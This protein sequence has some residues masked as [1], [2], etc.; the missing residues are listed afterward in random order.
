MDLPAFE[1]QVAKAC[2]SSDMK[3]LGKMI[4]EDRRAQALRIKWICHIPSVHGYQ[5]NDDSPLDTNDH[6]ISWCNAA[7]KHPKKKP[8]VSL[9][10]P[11]PEDP[12]NVAQRNAALAKTLRGIP[13]AVDATG[14]REHPENMSD[15]SDVDEY[16]VEL[17]K[18]NNVGNVDATIDRHTRIYQLPNDDNSYVLMTTGNRETWARALANPD[19]H[20]VSL[21][22]PPSNIRD[23]KKALKIKKRRVGVSGLFEPPQLVAPV[24]RG[25]ATMAAYLEFIEIEE[26]DR[27]LEILTRK[28]IKDYHNFLGGITKEELKDLGF[29]IGE[30][31]DLLD[32]VLRFDEHLSMNDH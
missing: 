10:M 21:T 13:A 4:T 9:I 5:K 17:A 22:S 11:K 14:S 24:V 23:S 27:I 32:N 20:G 2:S 12:V 6:F 1:A 8:V 15:V 16:E 18:L 31:R 3:Q 26:I 7:L 28:K 30:I 25:S 29:E 19:V